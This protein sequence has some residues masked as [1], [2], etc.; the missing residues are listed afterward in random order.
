MSDQDEAELTKQLHQLENDNREVSG[1]EQDE[2][3]DSN[4]S[5]GSAIGDDD[6]I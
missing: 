1:D 5:D 3:G 2:F 4:D 6:M